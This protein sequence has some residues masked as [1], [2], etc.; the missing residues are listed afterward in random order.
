MNVLKPYARHNMTRRSFLKYYGIASSALTISPFFIERMTAVCEASS[1]LT[2]VYKVKNAPPAGGNQNDFGYMSQTVT[3]L[4]DMLGGVSRFVDPTDIVVIKA[5]GQWANQGSTHTGGIKAVVDQI[6]AIPGFSGE[7]I[8][9]DN[10]QEYGQSGATGFDSTVANRVNNWTQ[11]NWTQLVADYRLPANNKPVGVHQWATD[12][13]WRTPPTPLPSFSLWNPS[14]GSTI[15]SGAATAWSRY[16][17]SFQGFNCY[18]SCPVFESP[19]TPGR[20]IDLRR[21]VWEGGTGGGY[22]SRK[23]KMIVMPTMNNHSY[24]GGSEDY[25]GMSSAVKSFFG[26]TEIWHNGTNNDS[27]TWNNYLSIHGATRFDFSNS[28]SALYA[29]QLVATYIKTFVTPVLYI[30]PAFYAGWYNRF[31]ASGAAFTNTVMACTNPVSLDWVAGR[32]VLSKAG[33]SKP[34]W[35]D[36]STLNNNTYRQLLGCSGAGIGTIDTTQMDVITYDFLNPT[37]TRLDIERKIRDYKAGKATQQDVK[38][39]IKLYMSAS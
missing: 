31:A 21:G 6:V 11:W 25:A 5:N 2:R 16:F 32:D 12:S 7:V 27:Y 24:G 23:V 8:I 39:V 35:T 37:A 4:F 18:L 17:F 1:S 33:T 13:V 20:I 9:C 15:P 10:L 14:T 30:N 29:G 34:T 38:D 22:T 28:Q 19:L 26:A 3:K 36:P